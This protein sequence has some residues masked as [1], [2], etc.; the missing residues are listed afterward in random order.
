MTGARRYTALPSTIAFNGRTL[1]SAFQPIYSVREGRA[2]G[3]EGLVRGTDSGGQPVRAGTLF[4]GM[5]DAEIVSLD[6][7]CRTLHLRSFAAIDPGKGTLFLNVHPIAA[8]SEAENVRWVRNRIG[9]FG[10]TPARVCVEIL[11]GACADEAR[12]VAAIAA[13]R[14]IGLQIAMDDFGVGRSNLVRV[15]ALRPDAVKLDRSMLADAVG[16][17]NARRLLPSVVELLHATGSKVMV[18]GIENASEALVAIESG[19]DFLQGHYF[20]VPA[21]QLHDDALSQRILGE[22]IRMRNASTP[23]QRTAGDS[24]L[25]RL[26]ERIK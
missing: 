9:Y 15:T 21:A 5:D 12:L 18:K 14:E 26:L 2:I 22:L 20:A 13:Y 16:D 1:A 7:T 3:Y 25:A 6:R 4:G 19:A 24:A 10:L 8:V 11:E 23:A 17:A